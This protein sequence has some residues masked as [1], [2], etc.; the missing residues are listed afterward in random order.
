MWTKMFHYIFG[1]MNTKTFENALVWIGP[2]WK[3]LLSK[4]TTAGK[5]SHI[6][7]PQKDH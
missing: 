5:K 1:N 4:G 6:L 7:S 3:G 2:Q